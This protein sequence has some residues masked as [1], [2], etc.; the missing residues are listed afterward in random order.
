[1]DAGKLE[2]GNWNP[3]TCDNIFVNAQA[4]TQAMKY[5]LNAL[6]SYINRIEGKEILEAK[7]M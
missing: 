7:F 6:K 1:M 3:T 2:N 5:E 4:I